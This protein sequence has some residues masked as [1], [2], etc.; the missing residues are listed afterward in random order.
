MKY[1]TKHLKLNQEL[2]FEPD[3][4]APRVREWKDGSFACRYA[5]ADGGWPLEH[6]RFYISPLA[7][8]N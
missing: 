4:C 2:Q 7:H 5:R 3:T 1:G 6:A 8:P